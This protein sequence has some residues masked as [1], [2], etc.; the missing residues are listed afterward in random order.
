MDSSC[1]SFAACPSALDF[2]TLAN[3]EATESFPSSIFARPR[4]T[5]LGTIGPFVCLFPLY[6]FTDFDCRPLLF[7]TLC[8]K[9]QSTSTT[10]NMAPSAANSETLDN[11]GNEIEPA[12]PG[13]SASS[14]QPKITPYCSVLTPLPLF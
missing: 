2:V 4:H 3:I 11:R 14:H 1:V 13:M 7:L 5:V 9:I 12:H 10:V 6:A 8:K